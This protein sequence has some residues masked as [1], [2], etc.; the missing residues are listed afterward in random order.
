MDFL[1]SVFFLDPI[2]NL[3]SKTSFEGL[4]ACR[5][6]ASCFWIRKLLLGAPGIPGRNPKNVFEAAPG[7]QISSDFSLQHKKVT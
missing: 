2:P 1:G 3:D 7:G 5:R 6:L 4:Q